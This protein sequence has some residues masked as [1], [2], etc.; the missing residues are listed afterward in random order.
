MYRQ[1]RRLTLEELSERLDEVA[2]VQISAAALL[3]VEQ[4]KR[5]VEAGDLVALALALQVGVA[6]LLAPSGDEPGDEVLVGAKAVARHDYLGVISAAGGAGDTDAAT[7]AVI[8]PTEQMQAIASAFA[9]VGAAA[10]EAARQF[11][12]ITSSA[13]TLQTIAATGH[14]RSGAASSVR[15]LRQAGYTTEQL[16]DRFG[17][18]ASLGEQPVR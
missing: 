4:G 6:G 12:M 2:G 1:A 7:E 13:T 11:S 14:P 10:G 3:R 8:V 9:A 16:R 15:L 17:P 5:G 18:G